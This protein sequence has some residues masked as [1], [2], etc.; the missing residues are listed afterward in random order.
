VIVSN[1][2]LLVIRMGVSLI[3]SAQSDDD[4][5]DDDDDAFRHL[6]YAA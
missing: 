3:L 4:D 1:E 2:Y 6:L 5:D